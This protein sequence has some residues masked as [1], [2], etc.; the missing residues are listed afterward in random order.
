VNGLRP[1]PHLTLWRWL[2]RAWLLAA[3]VVCLVPMPKSPIPIEGGDK[4]EHA[5]GWFAIT[6]WY[7]QLTAVPRALVAR[8][9]GFL[10]LGAAI[11][12]AQSLT[13][14]RSADPWDLVA[15]A[16]GVAMGVAIGLSPARG[17]LARIDR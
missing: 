1:L 7:A 4:L 9:C 10:A 5:L 2:G 15:N 3:V 17:I 11:E 14:W 8:A 6:I 13:T 16:A 12:L